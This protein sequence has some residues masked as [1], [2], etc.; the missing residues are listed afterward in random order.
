[1]KF[2]LPK[3]GGALPKPALPPT[4]AI[5]AVPTVPTP[6]VMGLAE[7]AISHPASTT[8]AESLPAWKTDGP[9][10]PGKRHRSLILFVLFA[11]IAVTG[12]FIGILH[13]LS[14]PVVPTVLPVV[15]T[16][17]HSGYTV[18]WMEEDRVALSEGGFLGH[19]L[20]EWGANPNRDQIRLRFRALAN[21]RPSQPV[22][23]YLASPAAVDDA[24][25]VFLLPADRIGDNPRNRLTLSELLAAIRE[26]PAHHRLLI[27][28]LVPQTEDPLY[29]QARN[30]LSIA[31]SSVLEKNADSNLLCIV[32]SG[33]GQVPVASADL[34]RTVFGW[35]LEAGL[36]GE[37]DGWDGGSVDGRVT[38][39]ELAA[40][41]HE[42]T[43]HWVT[44]TRGEAQ[45]PRM[46]GAGTDFTL[47]GISQNQADTEKPEPEFLF[48]D[49]L[50]ISWERRD[51]WQ[52]DG[53]AAAAPWAFRKLQASLMTAEREC[54]AGK[55]GAAVERDFG[56]QLLA[57]DQV[58]TALT[59]LPSPDPLPTL[60]ALYPGYVGPDSATLAELRDTMRRIDSRPPAPV[61]VP[62][63]G[64]KP[65]PEP[66]VP[67]EFD[68][69]KAKPHPS[70]ALAAFLL[71]SDDPDPT[72]ARLRSLDQVLATQT[73]M[74]R[75]A[76][77]AL[78]KRMANLAAQAP[79]VP[80]S[81]ERAALALQAERLFEAA[82]TPEVFAWASA[83]IEQTYRLKADAEAVYFAPGYASATEATHR[84]REAAAAARRLKDAAD[85][86]HNATATWHEAT[87]LLMGATEAVQ[88]GTIPFP[89]AEQLAN[90][91]GLLGDSLMPPA[92]PLDLVAFSQKATDW[93]SQ[94]NAVR[95]A[96]AE[97]M[98]QFRGD[99]LVKLRGRAESPEAG[100]AVVR[101][102]DLV[103]STPLLTAADRANMWNLRA[104]LNRRLAN[105]TLRSDTTSRE[106][107]RKGLASPPSVNPRE[108]ANEVAL[109]LEANRTRVRW[110]IALL[111]VGGLKESTLIEVRSN[112]NRLATDRF[113]FA[114]RLRRL[115]TDEVPSQLATLNP[116]SVARLAS[117]LPI[118]PAT[119]FLES[120]NT[121]PAVQRELASSR[122]MWMWQAGRFEYESR[123]LSGNDVALSFAMAAA[124]ACRTVAGTNAELYLEVTPTSVPKLTPEQ[125]TTTLQLNLRAVGINRPMDVRIS[126][127]SPSEGW[128]KTSNI[129]TVTL[130]PLRQSSDGLALAAGESPVSFPGALGVLVE[131]EAGGRTY[132]RRV[133]VILEEITDRLN[134]YIRSAP[135][136]PPIAA[137]QIRIR[138]NGV[139]QPYQL[140]LG[141]P[142]P[143]ERKVLVRLLGLSRETDVI[144]IAPGK[145][146]TLTFIAS[147]AMPQLPGQPGQA[148]PL[149]EGLPLKGDELVLQ[150]FDQ[151]DRDT[152]R[153]TIRLPVAVSNPA[154]YLRVTDPIFKPASGARSNRLSATIIPGDV[155]PGGPCQVHLS[156]PPDRNRGLII[157]DGSLMGAVAR[158]GPPLTLYAD[159][160]EL[161]RLS[162]TPVSVTISA[163]GMER[164]LTYSGSLLSTGETVRL[165]PLIT[166]RVEVKVEHIATGTKPLPVTLEVDNAPPGA[167]LEFVI[168]TEKDPNSPVEADLTLPIP[169][170]KAIAARV[171][172]D[173]KGDTLLLAGSI[174]DH[175][176]Q[177]PVELL[178]GK[179]V[180]EARLLDRDRR[181][182]AWDRQEVIFDG[183]PPQNVHFTDL[184][185][186]V[187]KDQPLAVR[188]V[189]DPTISG[190]KDV[191]FFLGTPDK[192]ELPKNPPPIAGKL[193]DADTNE[194]RAIIP[195]DGQKGVATVGVQFTTRAGLSKIETQDVELL[196]PM[197]LNKPVPGNIA[198]KLIE[199]KL[200]QP[201]L[202]VFLY[203]DKGNAKAKT[204]SKDDGSFE[205]KDVLPGAYYL[206]SEKETTNR[207][208]K[209]E[210]AVKAGETLQV[211]LELLLK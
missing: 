136:Q 70:L 123:E 14:P 119:A 23:V 71:L 193:F 21:V 143:R 103:L 75:F 192:N 95:T 185:P 77:T 211:T 85:R 163:D 40:F 111:R 49:W 3:L 160:L 79:A 187:R 47:R 15:I 210:I 55:P 195:V 86:L 137:Q 91:T 139:V 73:P 176:P 122:A 64:E 16:T 171:K 161:P 182:L 120:P 19:P 50:R 186:K 150:I 17:E 24:G 94:I 4:P 76:E 78:I 172:F 68:V 92:K 146:A 35:Y 124:R 131:A 162:G 155:P 125:T 145:T 144:A 198:G 87:E 148:P 184:P 181:R 159:H 88:R 174:K 13:W 82:I 61:G 177:L 9:P 133:P 5:P 27:L 191:K 39:N 157:R 104:A 62:A 196:D 6:D 149:D 67:P 153:Q 59:V 170:A 142:T 180:L 29:S 58:S 96:I 105:E 72:P 179:R 203:D 151:A 118:V 107:I 132:H 188:A 190:I 134:L 41:L 200:A 97:F 26:C 207:H 60:A 202:V 164:V 115:W 130:D 99:A 175:E 168:G 93:D 1:M 106:A 66:L 45:S 204:T 140:L 89:V 126:S 141:N 53:R 18:P 46:I 31:I 37:A 57:A 201:G 32:S 65:V 34:G 169:T 121:N 135:G 48:P 166:P 112:L 20:D 30:D 33:P 102:L 69:F 25:G 74:P 28:N 167:T 8:P 11:L 183:T 54:L 209:K 199:G 173:P 44:A 80:W 100:P 165:T 138:P 109:D 2:E 52:R 84:L 113:A 154:D 194:Y 197:E 108:G 22:V 7:K 208:I 156:F 158:G 10:L 189:C 117:V 90:S 98:R 43:G 205:F 81:P 178:V 51:Q 56:R 152:V 127:L 38:V 129:K 206:F 83:A 36:R 63:P 12:S 147:I 101:E 114:D 128:V 42:K 116:E 110:S